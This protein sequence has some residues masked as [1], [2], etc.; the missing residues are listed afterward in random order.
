MFYFIKF[1]HLEENEDASVWVSRLILPRILTAIHR[2]ITASTGGIN[3]V[4]FLKERQ[5]QVQSFVGYVRLYPQTQLNILYESYVI[6]SCPT[7]S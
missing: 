2:P 3:I 5:R 7:S 4:F 6:A 1:H